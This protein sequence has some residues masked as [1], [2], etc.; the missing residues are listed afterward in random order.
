MSVYLKQAMLMLLVV[1]APF[2]KADTKKLFC[3][4]LDSSGFTH[5]FRRSYFNTKRYALDVDFDNPSLNGGGEDI[6]MYGANCQTK[7]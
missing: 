4:E 3:F 1:T 2:S 6:G 7:T 5:D